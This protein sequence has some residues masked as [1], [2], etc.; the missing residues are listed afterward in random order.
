MIYI[1]IYMLQTSGHVCL[2]SFVQ[3]M[4]T[5]YI[6]CML[7]VHLL[8]WRR[9][10]NREESHTDTIPLRLPR[11]H[12]SDIC[13]GICFGRAL[14]PFN[15]RRKLDLCRSAELGIYEAS[16]I[17]FPPTN[18]KLVISYRCCLKLELCKVVYPD[19]E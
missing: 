15:L 10:K 17:L 8:K 19:N 7:D 2:G 12:K 18:R 14:P 16:V 6:D 3:S 13:T 11:E 5:I 4:K 1:Y 9:K